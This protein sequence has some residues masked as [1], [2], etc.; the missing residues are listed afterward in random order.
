VYTSASLAFMT[1]GI[2]TKES[3]FIF[4]L[5]LLVL[6]LTEETFSWQRIGGL[7][8]FFTVAAA[9]FFYRWTL[10]GGIGG[11]QDVRT[12]APQIL[13]LSVIHALKA[14][15]LRVWAILFFPI[16]WSQ[17]PAKGL[18]VLMVAYALALV[19]VAVVR[20]RRTELVFPLAFVLVTVLP[21]LHLLLIGTDLLKSR[22][23]YLPSVGFCLM[24]GSAV[25]HLRGWYRWATGI[26]IL[27]FHFFALQHN[28]D[29][30]KYAAAKAQSASATALS[31]IAPGTQKVTISGLPGTLRGV[32]FFANGFPEAISLRRNLQSIPVMNDGGTVSTGPTADCGLVW[33]GTNDELRVQV[34][35]SAFAPRP[36]G[37]R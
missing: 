21:A 35:P 28:L 7:I 4:P 13:T 37:A 32:P 29:A 3:A 26:T 15:F 1:L 22:L 31:C 5:L 25:A 16:N 34:L 14:L 36:P 18:A 27:T 17:E 23:L 20:V 30:W 8:S 24:L 9:L 19:A 11:Y 33:D 12:G 10:L 6:I 2:L